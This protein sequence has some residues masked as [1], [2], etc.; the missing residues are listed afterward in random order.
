MHKLRLRSASN[1]VS[2]RLPLF[3]S[4]WV[5]P[6]SLCLSIE[7]MSAKFHQVLG[8]WRCGKKVLNSGARVALAGV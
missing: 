8:R 6:V 2:V 4:L 7:R 1:W 3:P 5:F